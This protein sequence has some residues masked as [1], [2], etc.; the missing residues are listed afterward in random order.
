MKRLDFLGNGK[1]ANIDNASKEFARFFA[2]MMDI[3]NFPILR[4][5]LP[6]AREL[7]DEE[8]MAEVRQANVLVGG[9]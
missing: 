6:A 4:D 5:L 1:D 2:E 8:L 7:T 9:F 3:K